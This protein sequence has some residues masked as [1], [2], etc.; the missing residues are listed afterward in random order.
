MSTATWANTI[1]VG[2]LA[3]MLIVAIVGGS[4]WLGRMAAQVDG[5]S[6]DISS[7]TDEVREMRDEQRKT[8]RILVALAN[9]THTEDGRAYFVLPFDGD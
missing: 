9:H 8:N 1:G 4:V 5:L 7:L 6:S 3:I 2:T